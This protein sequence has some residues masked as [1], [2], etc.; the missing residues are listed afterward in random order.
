MGGGRGGEG[1]RESLQKEEE[2]KEKMHTVPYGNI[3]SRRTI[4]V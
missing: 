4:C 3:F 1:G 2:R